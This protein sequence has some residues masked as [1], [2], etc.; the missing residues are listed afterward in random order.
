MRNRS[1]LVYR[2]LKL[3]GG[4]DDSR[5][6]VVPKFIR[7]NF[8]SVPGIATGGFQFFELFCGLTLLIP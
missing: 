4:V 6:K 8:N 3:G 5:F 7:G 2:L 1:E